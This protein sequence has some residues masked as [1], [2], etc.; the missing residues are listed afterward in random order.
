VKREPVKPALILPLL[1]LIL[2]LLPSCSSLSK[3]PLKHRSDH[4]D[5]KQLGDSGQTPR[6]QPPAGLSM[7]LSALFAQ[8]EEAQGSS[9]K[10]VFVNVTLRNQTHQDLSFDWRSWWLRTDDGRRFTPS[11]MEIYNEATGKYEPAPTGIPAG[12][13]QT[14]TLTIPTGSRLRI[15]LIITLVLH[16]RF[17]LGSKNHSIASYFQAG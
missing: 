16:W 7:D 15:E 10:A 17:R 4:V 9:K 6:F 14:M 2:G 12:K 13:S 3:V 11:K 5:D 1:L 8:D